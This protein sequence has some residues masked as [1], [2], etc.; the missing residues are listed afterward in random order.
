MKTDLASLSCSCPYLGHALTLP[1]SFVQTPM[2]KH[3]KKQER[4]E[5]ERQKSFLL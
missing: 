2:Y 5:C 1:A 3:V 4:K